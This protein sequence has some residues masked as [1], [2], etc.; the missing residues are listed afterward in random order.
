[1]I[2]QLEQGYCWTYRIWERNHMVHDWKKKKN[3]LMCFVFLWVLE[4]KGKKINFKRALAGVAQ[5]IEF[6]PENQRVTSSIPSQGTCLGCGPG[7]QYG[8]RWQEAAIHGCLSPSLSPPLPLS[9]KINKWNL[10]KKII[11]PWILVIYPW[12]QAWFCQWAVSQH[13]DDSLL[14]RRVVLAYEFHCFDKD[15]M[16]VFNQD[17]FISF[18]WRSLS[19]R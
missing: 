10:L 13:P 17:R 2:S 7:P 12:M 6:W 4:A 19:S 1:M 16:T 11:Y 3:E 14:P 8:E 5:W 15:Q 9:L 18:S